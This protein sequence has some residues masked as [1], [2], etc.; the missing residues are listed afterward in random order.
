V[1]RGVPFDPDAP[2]PIST[3][4]KTATTGDGISLLQSLISSVNSKAAARRALFSLPLEL[5][6]GLKIG[7]KGY[8]LIKRQ[9]VVK[10]CWIW[11]GGEKLQIAVGSTTNIA[12]ETARTVQQAEIQK[13]YIF[14]G[15]QIVFEEDEA[16]S[17][18]YFG[19]PA[20]RIIG[21]KPMNLLPEWANCRTPTFVYPD[22]S[23]YVGSSRVFSALHQKLLASQKF[24]LTWT[25]SRRNVTPILAALIPGAEKLDESG[26][27]WLPPGMWLVPLPYAD[28]IRQNP[29][30]PL[31]RAPAEL[32]DR[33]KDIMNL[34]RLPKDLYDPHK[35]PNPCRSRKIKLP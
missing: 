8:T 31:V 29:P 7:V 35:Y 22:E 4:A 14:G 12:E 24:A 23:T 32:V 21:F 19:D 11:V 13:A 6:P 28:D 15:E 34:L 27:Q 18:R 5:G 10:S 30:T 20:I 9:E 33:M 3:A 16:K 26:E 17:L 25:I 1:Y 2:A